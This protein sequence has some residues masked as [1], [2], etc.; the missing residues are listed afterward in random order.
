MKKL[1][2]LTLCLVLILSLTTGSALAAFTDQG[3]I[4]HSEAVNRCVELNIIGGYA[5]GSYRPQSNVTRAELSK[6]LSVALNGGSTPALPSTGSTFVDSKGH[7]ATQ[8]I[9]Y[10]VQRD[11]VA[12][13]G[14]GRV[15]PDGY[16]TGTQAA[17]MLLVVLGFDPAVQGYVGSSLWSE[18]INTDASDVGLYDGLRSFDPSV[19]LTRDQAAQMIWNTLNS[20]M[21]EWRKESNVIHIDYLNE[22]LLSH[23]YPNFAIPDDP[24]PDDPTPDTPNKNTTLIDYIGMTKSEISQMWGSDYIETQGGEMGADSK[25]YYEDLRIPA[26]FSLNDDTVVLVF[27]FPKTMNSDFV[28]TKSF[29]GRETYT[30]LCDKGISGDFVTVDNDPD[31][32]LGWNYFETAAFSFEYEGKFVYFS[33]LNEDPY[34]TPANFVFVG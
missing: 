6:M 27:C 7:W 33:W 31:E 17:K 16:V 14:G 11:I 23:C 28:L 8:Y 18:N 5:D 15:N 24:T 32:V 12:G 34:T 13:V 21:V 10:C 29:T 20:S 4:Q 9:E 26:E 1:L 19:P 3:T 25:L 30:Q 2:S 22:T